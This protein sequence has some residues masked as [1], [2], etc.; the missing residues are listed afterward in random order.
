MPVNLNKFSP[1][2]CVH[3][4]LI[5]NTFNVRTHNCLVASSYFKIPLLTRI[6][7]YPWQPRRR[8]LKDHFVVPYHRI[9]SRDFFEERLR[10]VTFLERILQ[11]TDYKE[12][13]IPGKPNSTYWRTGFVAWKW[14][15]GV[16]CKNT[17]RIFVWQWFDYWSE[18]ENKH[19]I[20]MS[21]QWSVIM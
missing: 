18:M 6:G 9:I 1:F 21:C 19:F 11:L 8:A 5:K 12:W 20:C 16:I 3:L 10:D 2:L 15:K 17:N 13:N 14:R 4:H 7:S